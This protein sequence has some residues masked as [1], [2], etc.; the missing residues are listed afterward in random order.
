MLGWIGLTIGLS[1]VYSTAATQGGGQMRS[2]GSLGQSWLLLLFIVVAT[3]L[4]ASNLLENGDLEGEDT[5]EFMSIHAHT[6]KWSV[7][8]EDD[9][10]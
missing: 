10:N 4:S 1:V 6:F 9:G 7:F 5:S 3:E 2:Q 8:V